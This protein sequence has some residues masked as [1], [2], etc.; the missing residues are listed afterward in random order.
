MQH[1]PLNIVTLGDDSF[2]AVN[3]KVTS[4]PNGDDGIDDKVDNN[5]E[6]AHVGE[7]KGT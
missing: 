7:G 5:N 4:N 1:D 3:L 2:F 6:D